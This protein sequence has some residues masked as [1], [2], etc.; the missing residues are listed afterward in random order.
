MDIKEVRRLKKDILSWKGTIGRNIE[1]F[2]YNRGLVQASVNRSFEYYH[3]LCND[4][5]G[6]LGVAKKAFE[7]ST[8]K[9]FINVNLTAEQ[10]EAYATWDI[11]DADVWD[12]LATYGEQ[13]YKFS[14][15]YNKSNSSWVAAY[16]GQDGSG[17]NEGYA[18]TGFAKDPYNA[19]RVLLFK[20]SS[21]LPDVWKDYKPLPSDEIG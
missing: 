10:K 8:W 16:T 7:N 2:S 21:L 11:A 5:R 19:A 20:V 14:L 3:R 9:G 13:G 18:V 6:E 17:K 1:A 4:L 15:T 12:G